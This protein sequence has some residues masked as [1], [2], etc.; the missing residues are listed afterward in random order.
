MPYQIDLIEYFGLAAV[1]SLEL[2]PSVAMLEIYE[3]GR[4]TYDGQDISAQVDAACGDEPVAEAPQVPATN[5]I[6]LEN[7]VIEG[8]IE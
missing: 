5:P 4:V 2:E 3:D 6:N 8:T 1:P 7:D